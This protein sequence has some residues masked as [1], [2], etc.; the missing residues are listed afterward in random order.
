M[1]LVVDDAVA[2]ALVGWVVEMPSKS[3]P[4]AISKVAFNLFF[5]FMFSSSL[6]KLI[7]SPKKL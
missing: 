5:V 3:A 2:L 7:G 6:F 1:V 4:A